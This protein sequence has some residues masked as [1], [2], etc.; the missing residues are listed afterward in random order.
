MG[1]FEIVAVTDDDGG[2]DEQEEACGYEHF[3]AA[4]GSAPFFE[5]ETPECGEED[6]A[7]HVKGPTGEIVLAHFCLAH[8]VEEELEVPDDASEGGQDVVGS[9]GALGEAVVGGDVEGV[10][11]DE[12]VAG[13]MGGAHGVAAGCAGELADGFVFEDQD[14]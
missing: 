13:G 7:R 1:G 5:R 11:V 3:G 4:A 2:A 6:N 14:C 10:I 12:G 9:E 8:G